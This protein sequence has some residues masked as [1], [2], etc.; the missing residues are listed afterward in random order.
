MGH[1]TSWSSRGAVGHED[2]TFAPSETRRAKSSSKLLSLFAQANIPEETLAVLRV[3]QMTAL[4][5]PNGGVRGMV[6]G[7]VVR[8]LIAKTMAMQF[9]TRFETATKP[10]HYAGCESIAH[11]AQVH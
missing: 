2:R 4:Q 11:A 6:V 7:D 8:R 9:M 1:G 10:F 3:V 5:K